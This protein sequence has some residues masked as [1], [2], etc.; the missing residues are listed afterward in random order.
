MTQ[1]QPPDRSAALRHALQTLAADLA[2]DEAD[3][4]SEQTRVVAACEV[5]GR[6]KF[7]LRASSFAMATL[8]R[9]A[10]IS[11]SAERLAWARELEGLD[12]DQLFAATTLV[13][14]AA[15]LQQDKQVLAGPVLRFL[16]AQD[17]LR[18]IP[19]P[20]ATTI[21]L[22][23]REHIPQLCAHKGFHNALSYR[24]DSPRPDVLA[25]VAQRAEAVIGIAGA[26]ADADRLWQ[27]G[28]DVRAEHRG[29]GVGKALVSHLTKAILADGKVP[30]YS[31]LAS[32]LQSSNLALSVGYWLAWIEVYAQES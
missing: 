3:L 1:L 13:K 29:S 18:T 24:V 17:S 32:N 14:I 19:A 27:V 11:C 25:A 22:V 4:L 6:R 30:Y 8:G 7:P 12:R 26:S 21:T 23:S 31:T 2:C 15:L 10:V 20:D 28:V 9:G 16:C 5:L